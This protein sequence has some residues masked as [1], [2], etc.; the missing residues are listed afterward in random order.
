MVTLEVNYKYLI[1][2]YNNF[3][4]DNLDSWCCS[5]TFDVPENNKASNLIQ[6]ISNKV[7]IQY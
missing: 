7:Y 1:R 3:V 4:S 5:L 6:Q 2:N